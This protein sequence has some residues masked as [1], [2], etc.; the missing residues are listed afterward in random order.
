MLVDTD[1]EPSGSHYPVLTLPT[2]LTRDIFLH[3]VSSHIRTLED[4]SA[5][6]IMY[7]AA[8]LARVCRAWRTIA[9]SHPR[10]WAYISIV[11]ETLNP[12]EMIHLWVSRSQVLDLDLRFVPNVYAREEEVESPAQIERFW[13]IFNVLCQY[14]SQWGNVHISLYHTTH[15]EVIL[16]LPPSMPQL[17]RLSIVENSFDDDDW[18]VGPEVE[19]IPLVA[20]LLWDLSLSSQ[21]ARCSGALRCGI[22]RLEL[23]H[24]NILDNF[25]RI[26]ALVPQLQYLSCAFFPHFI[27]EDPLHPPPPVSLAALRTL[28]LDAWGDWDAMGQEEFAEVLR[29]VTFP[30]LESLILSNIDGGVVRGI[31]G[32][33]TRSGCTRGV[34]EL[35][36]SLHAYELHWPWQIDIDSYLHLLSQLPNLQTLALHHIAP[37]RRTTP[38]H[39]CLWQR[40]CR[41]G[42]RRRGQSRSSPSRW[43]CEDWTTRMPIILWPKAISFL[44][45]ICK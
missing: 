35:D 34:Q 24:C 22:T 21:F 32:L 4:H 26:L 12:L 3:A 23:S 10:L 36:I 30:K 13:E 43:T 28:K 8:R 20:P 15:G 40:S 45:W 9:L 44:G 39:S 2:E 31:V 19:S 17:R 33:I 11:D 5:S 38:A 1:L 7:T 42:G 37:S 27:S 16:R 6:P 41:S 14:A 29:Y 18:V 25:S